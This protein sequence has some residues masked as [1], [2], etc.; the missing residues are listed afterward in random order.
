[1][2]EGGDLDFDVKEITAGLRIDILL[3]STNYPKCNDS[4]DE[5]G[6]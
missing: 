1:M 5:T 6:T 4:G 2:A 3:S